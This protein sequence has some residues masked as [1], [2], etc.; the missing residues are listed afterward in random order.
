MSEKIQLIINQIKEH[1]IS[2]IAIIS[3][4]SADPDAIA[5]SLALKELITKYFPKINVYIYA[6]SISLVSQKLLEETEEQIFQNMNNNV[7]NKIE[8]IILCDTNNPI[9]LG[10]IDISFAIKSN[11]PI[12]IIDHHIAH[13]FTKKVK[14]AI[15]EQVPS[16]A[17]IIVSFYKTLQLSPAP[18]TA[19]LLLSGILFDTRR[20]MYVSKNTFQ[21]VEYLIDAGG[22]YQKALSLLRQTISFPE[23]MARLKGLSRIVLKTEN[24]TIFAFSHVSSFESSLA[25]TLCDIGADFSAVI[26]RPSSSILRISLRCTRN[27]L[28][29]YKID[30][31]TIANEISNRFSGTGGGHETAA[32]INITD[33]S[34]FPRDKGKLVKFFINQL[35]DII[36]CQS[37]SEGEN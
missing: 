7:K 23:R 22:N 5:S 13:D 4:H 6:A 17:E 30:L 29:K 14:L 27:F 36:S 18:N 26:A 32:G 34:P 1:N 28:K 2:T 25:R 8:A 19:T 16:T 31:A 15:I 24:D 3:H 9:Q 12:F 10:E 20:F 37:S 11:I 21:I 33:L 35:F